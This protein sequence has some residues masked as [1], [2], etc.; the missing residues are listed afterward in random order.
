MVAGGQSFAQAFDALAQQIR[1]GGAAA[2]TSQPF[3]ETVLAGSTKFCGPPATSCTAGVVSTFSGQIT[4]QRVRDVFNGIRTEFKTLGPAT[5]AATQFNNFFFWSGLGRSNYNAGFITYHIRAY[6]GL[7]LD[8]NFGYSHSLDTVPFNQDSDGA[9]SNSYDPHYDY[10]TSVFDRKF[11]FTLLGVW[12]LPLRP[13]S[14]WLKEAVGGWQVSPIVSI[15]S[16]LPLEI[17]NAGS[18][19]SVGSGQEFG[20]TGFGAAS[21]AVRIGSGNASTGV[22]HV[23]PTTGAGSTASGKGSG[24]NVLPIPKRS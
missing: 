17:M 2:A 22:N 6:Q 15:A 3:F 19:L 24:L 13:Q 20:Q 1:T 7:T 14:S 9:F 18:P 16:G 10:G 4:S 21:E 11:V 23:A 5:N 12:E 8:A